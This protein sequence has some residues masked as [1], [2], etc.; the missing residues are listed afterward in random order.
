MLFLPLLFASAALAASECTT[1]TTTFDFTQGESSDWS[2]Q[3]GDAG[4]SYGS[5]GVVLEVIE[6]RQT[7]VLMSSQAFGKRFSDIVH[8]S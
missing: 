7:V 6:D 1:T 5:D 2:I 4:V 8:N 3:A